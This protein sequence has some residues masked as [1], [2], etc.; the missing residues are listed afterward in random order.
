MSYGRGGFLMV[1]EGF[2]ESPKPAPPDL[3]RDRRGDIVKRGQER[4]IGG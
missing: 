3:K 4:R 1:I 2:K